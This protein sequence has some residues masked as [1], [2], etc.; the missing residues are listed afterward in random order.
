MPNDF[1]IIWSD[2]FQLVVLIY[3]IWIIEYNE[4]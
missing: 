4:N 2:L 3:N 1:D